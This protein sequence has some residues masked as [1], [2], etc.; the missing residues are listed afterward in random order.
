MQWS[1]AALQFC[2]RCFITSE[3]GWRDILASLV[4][5]DLYIYI[6]FPFSGNPCLQVVL[7]MCSY[8]SAGVF[9][10]LSFHPVRILCELLCLKLP[11]LQIASFSPCFQKR[12][13]EYI[14]SETA[15][16]KFN[17]VPRV[18][19]FLPSLFFI[20]KKEER[21]EEFL[22]T[23]WSLLSP[24]SWSDP[25][26]P[27]CMSW[28][29]NNETNAVIKIITGTFFNHCISLCGDKVEILIN[30]KEKLLYFEKKGGESINCQQNPLCSLCR[31]SHV[32]I[33]VPYH[34]CC[35]GTLHL[36]WLQ[37]FKLASRTL[38]QFSCRNKPSTFPL[39]SQSSSS[40]S[41]W[42]CV[43]AAD[44]LTKDS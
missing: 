36:I 35:V 32:S 3:T 25:P 8:C 37:C 28:A 6:V 5:W 29:D 40:Y 43:F 20:K 18:Q 30:D 7:H 14:T 9:K 27:V 26:Q 1:H 31:I 2:N 22:N 42:I 41:S 4:F 10:P 15:L 39:F 11:L 12:L 16:E 24:R 19:V 33:S 44:K 17:K 34:V 23:L 38:Q 21:H 13:M